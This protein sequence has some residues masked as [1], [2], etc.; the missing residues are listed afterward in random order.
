[1]ASREFR[2]WGGQ[3]FDNLLTFGGVPGL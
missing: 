1:M 2:G 3:F